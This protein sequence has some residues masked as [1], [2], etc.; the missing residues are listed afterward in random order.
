[1]TLNQGSIRP[2]N[3]GRSSVATYPQ[4]RLHQVAVCKTAPRPKTSSMISAPVTITGRSSRRYTTSVV[5]EEVRHW[6]KDL[7][8]KRRTFAERLADRQNL[9]IAS[10]DA[11]YGVISAW[12]SRP[13]PVQPRTPSCSRPSPRSRRP[14]RS[15][16]A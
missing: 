8:A 16:S 10:E 14:R 15:S 9:K 1:M 5:W 11:D 2:A 3:A 12:L 7:A 6:I 13:G 4:A